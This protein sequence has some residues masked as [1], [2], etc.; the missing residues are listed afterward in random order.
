MQIPCSVPGVYSRRAQ[1][2][3]HGSAETFKMQGEKL[4]LTLNYTAL[5]HQRPLP[6]GPWDRIFPLGTSAPQHQVSKMPSGSPVTT[7]L[8]ICPARAQTLLRKGYF[9]TE[10]PIHSISLPPTAKQS[11][12]MG[13]SSTTVSFIPACLLPRRAG[14]N[15][16][17][18][19]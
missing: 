4:L 9:G 12:S 5:S 7:Q 2:C 15:T 14:D 3:H 16:D 1:L 13:F 6:T 8:H 11:S 17:Y 19:R 10:K 18:S